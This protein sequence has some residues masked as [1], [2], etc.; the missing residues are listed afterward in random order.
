MVRDAAMESAGAELLESASKH[1]YPNYR[2]PPIVLE[3]GQGSEVWDTSGKRYLDLAAGIAVTSLGHAHPALVRAIAEQAG[4][5][6]HVS[7]Y[8][9]NAENLKLAA[10]LTRATGMDRA[11]FCNSGTEALEAC[12]KLVR[13]FHFAKGE[14]ERFRVVAFE[15]SF[16]GRTLGALAA[17][18]QKA[19]REGFG[20]MGGVTHVSYGDVAAVRA[21]MGPDVAAI[22]VEPVQGEGGVLPAPAGFLRALRSIADEHG[23]LLVADEVQT[24]I[25]RT[26]KFLAFEHAG[27]APD[28][29]ALAKGLGGGV[30]IGAMLCKE[31]LAGA[32]PPG[33]HGST[34]GGNALVSAAALAVLA[35]LETEGLVQGASDKGAHLSRLLQSLT[36]RHERHVEGTRGLGLLQALVLR[37]SVDARNVVGS[38]RDAGLLVTIAGSRALRFSPALTVSIPELD[39]GAAIVDRVL[40]GL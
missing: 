13:R 20:P 4:R 9:Y 6:I 19:Y 33:S 36:A 14:T 2:Q 12:L 11:F 38:L 39:E 27:V 37:E 17:T 21:A 34:F 5:L 24:G 16:H 10:R 7:N 29:V 26:G 1:L 22:L 18:G 32:L 23:A 35:T 3:R 31:S 15:H 30:P 40:G 25:G 28:V 8:F